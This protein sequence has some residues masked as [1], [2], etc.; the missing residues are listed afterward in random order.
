M[1]SLKNTKHI[2]TSPRVELLAPAGSPEALEAAVAAGADAVYFGASSHNARM[3]A[4]NF[5]DD[6]LADALKLCRSAGVKTNIT[7]N[8]LVYDREL[9]ELMK[10][11]ER[12]YILGCDALIVADLG[13]AA[14]IHKY[15]PD[16]ELHASTQV[17]GHNLAA[18]E[19]LRDLGF[20]RM[21]AARELSY[22]NLK[23][24]CEKSPIETELF[25][26]GAICVS[27]SGQCLASSMIGGRSG[28]RGACAQPCRLCYSTPENKKPRPALSLKDMCLAG[29]IPELLS[30]GAASF[31]IEGRMKSPEYVYGVTSIW[32]RL[33]DER[34]SAT[35]DEMA[36]LASL[37]SRSG[38]TDGYFT[39]HIDRKMVGV[40]TESDKAQSRDATRQISRNKVDYTALCKKRRLPIELA[41]SFSVGELSRLTLTSGANE[42]TVVGC[43]P[44]LAQ[45]RPMSREDIEKNLCRFGST[46]FEVTKA[47]IS[48]GSEPLIL[49]VSELNSLR[50]SASEELERLLFCEREAVKLPTPADLRLPRPDIAEQKTVRFASPERMPDT[51]LLS[52]FDIVYLPLERLFEQDYSADRKPVNCKSVNREVNGYKLTAAAE[53]AIASLPQEKRGVILPPVIFDD[54]TADI[55]SM[56]AAAKAAGVIH[57]LISNLGHI[58]LAADAGLTPHGDF[59]LNITNAHTARTLTSL[60][61]VDLIASPELTLAQLRDL[62]LSPILYGRVPIMTL[63]KCVIRDLYSCEDCRESEFL[64]MVDRRGVE[65]PLTRAWRHR[66]IMYNSVPFYTADR[67]DELAA[68]KIN[69]GHY[70]FSVETASEAASLI[71]AMRKGLAPTGAFRRI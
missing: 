15:F 60:G 63:E 64:P 31:K 52:D 12:L 8:T 38:F 37:F 39:G 65:F 35:P 46:P 29:H 70:I 48:L 56:L 13:A 45:N 7:V 11:V 43:I 66:N 61:F 50:R 16:L 23:L 69:G 24:L 55:A 40:R 21:V 51:E 42:V 3:G 33:I 49:R 36:E 30:L 25:I 34:R 22:A 54:E 47:D 59:R 53:I 1:L 71:E 44:E 26:H 19:K 41:A 27:Q 28:N 68:A 10:T 5:G 32:R 67:A 2:A 14:L 4:K 6:E 62:G 58:S 57:A 20:S 9:P 18:A 17:A